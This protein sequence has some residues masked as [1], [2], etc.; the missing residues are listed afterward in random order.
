MG[1]CCFND[2]TCNDTTTEASCSSVGGVYQGVGTFCAL[3]SCVVGVEIDIKPGSDPNSI[4]P[5]SRGVIPM[6]LVGSECFDVADVDV[7][8][9]AFG[10]AGA[11]PAHRNGGHLEDVND[12]G[13]TDLLVHFRVDETGIAAG[14]TEGCLTGETLD[15]T[16]FEGC[17]AVR[18]VGPRVVKV[19]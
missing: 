5:T 2:G 7:T 4:N 9:L 13:F 16:P 3:V 8:T 12:D 17:D 6:L 14:D 11:A 10:P 18:T 15:G 1:A 19:R